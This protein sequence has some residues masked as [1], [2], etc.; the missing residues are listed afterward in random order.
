MRVSTWECVRVHQITMAMWFLSAAAFMAMA[1][2]LFIP[3][4]VR[5]NTDFLFGVLGITQLVPEKIF[6]Y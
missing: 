1:F 3:E 5:G 2:R 4:W 6:V